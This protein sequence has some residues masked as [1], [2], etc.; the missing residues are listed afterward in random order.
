MQ[1]RVDTDPRAVAMA[2]A[3]VVCGV[4]TDDPRAV[5]ALPTG[6]TPLPA[7]RELARRR[8]L[9]HVSFSHVTVFLLDEYVG[10]APDDPRSFRAFGE[11]HLIEPLGLRG[12]RFFALQGSAADLP[13]E[14]AA[15]EASITA[16]GGIALVVLGLGGNGHIAFNEPGS[17]P[18][19]RTR[20]VQLA[21]ETIAPSLPSTAVTI[22]VGT[23]REA[24]RVLLVAT[25]SH[26]AAALTAAVCGPATTDLPASL[27]RG[28]EH[29][30]VIADDLAMPAGAAR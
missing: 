12:D 8:R 21:S 26:K 10:L 30:Q 5:L 19:S 28:H 23:I 1:L 29:L 27:L 11:R 6:S 3:D 24:R 22:G 4:V 7:Y 18:D 16:A 17:S 9:G 13:A 14:C 15:Y 20:V 2:V 25:G